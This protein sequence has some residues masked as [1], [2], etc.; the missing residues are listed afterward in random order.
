MER[1]DFIDLMMRPE[2]GDQMA[3]RLDKENPEDGRTFSLEGVGAMTENMQAFAVARTFA[4]WQATGKPPRRMTATVT[5]AWDDDV[6]LDEGPP[7]W[8]ADDKGMT[9]VDGEDRIRARMLN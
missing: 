2:A 4:R 3:F 6:D 5:L 8:Q 1:D 7:W 9:L